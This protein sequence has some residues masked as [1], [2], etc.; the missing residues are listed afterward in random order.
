[1]KRKSPVKI[2]RCSSCKSEFRSTRVYGKW[3]ATCSARC[4]IEALS[5][6]IERLERTR[7]SLAATVE[8]EPVQPPP[9]SPVVKAS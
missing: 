5:R 8:A 1:M 7:A 3:T 4:R 6:L 9:E 2:R